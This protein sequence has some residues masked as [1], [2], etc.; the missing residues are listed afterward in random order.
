MVIGVLLGSLAGYF[1]GW[2]DTIISRITEVTMAFPLLL[3]IVALAATVGPQLD[4]ITFGG[5]FPNGVV[6]LVLIF[7]SS[8]GSTR[9]GSCARRCSRSARRNTSRP[10][11]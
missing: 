4:A 9:P 2:P 7:T 10:P 11:G 8:A 5:L 3:F 1:R 6:T